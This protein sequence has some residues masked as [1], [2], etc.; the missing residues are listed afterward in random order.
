[1]VSSMECTDNGPRKVFD[2]DRAARLCAERYMTRG[3]SSYQL[4]EFAYQSARE[5]NVTGF[6]PWYL[7]KDWD[8]LPN[9][10]QKFL[11]YLIRFGRR[12]WN[13]R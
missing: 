11:A 4:A 3:M 8:E 13:G 9:S 12:N 1:M 7:R 10:Y 2:L 5:N 6:L